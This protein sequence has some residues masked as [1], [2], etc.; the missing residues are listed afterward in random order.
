VSHLLCIQK[1]K[2][3]EKYHSQFDKRLDCLHIQWIPL[4]EF[5]S[6]DFFME[7]EA[8]RKMLELCVA[9]CDGGYRG[10]KAEELFSGS[11]ARPTHYFYAQ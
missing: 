7:S 5:Q 4:E 9:S 8:R 3:K 11:L 1:K 6:Q 2:E 10:F